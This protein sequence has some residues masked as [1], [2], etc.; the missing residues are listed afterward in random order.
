ME[1]ED[2]QSRRHGDRWQFKREV[3]TG[4]ILIAIGFIIS[5][6]MGYASMDKRISVVEEKQAMQARIDQQQDS[7]VRDGMARIEV[8]LS[9]IQRFLRDA[10][11]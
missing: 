5:A 2:E 6:M 1:G 8:A 7:T 4:D 10:K 3:S 9:D 11:K